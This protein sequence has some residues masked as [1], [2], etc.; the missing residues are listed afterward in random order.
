MNIDEEIK[1]IIKKKDYDFWIFLEK[2]YENNVK[3]DIGHFI[4]LNL[5]IGIYD[6][7]KNL[8]DSLGEDRAKEIF[9]SYKIFAKNSDYIS[10]E[11]LKKYINR[12]SRVAVH[13]RIK[14]LKS[15]GFKI[16]SKSGAYGG[17]KLIDVPEWFKR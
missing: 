5:L 2:A 8:C 3:L 4:L 9:N 12:K 11:F 10:G 14:D 15:L 17:Y 7:Y 13:N 6:L 16:E 1:K